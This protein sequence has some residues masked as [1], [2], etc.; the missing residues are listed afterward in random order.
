VERVCTGFGDC[1]FQRG[2]CDMLLDS[3]ND[4]EVHEGKLSLSRP[5]Q[6]SGLALGLGRAF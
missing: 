4:S 6:K 5:Y 1:G 2:G 3:I